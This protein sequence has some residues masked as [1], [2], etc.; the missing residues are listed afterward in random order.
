[1][2]KTLSV[3]VFVLFWELVIVV[4]VT[5]IVTVSVLCYLFCIM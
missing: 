5:F 4:V 1:L 3:H 2:T